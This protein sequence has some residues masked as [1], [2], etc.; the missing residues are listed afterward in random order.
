MPDGQKGVVSTRFYR[1]PGHVF[2]PLRR[3][4]DRAGAVLAVGAT[5]DEALARADA[6]AERIRFVTADAPALPDG[7]FPDGRAPDD[8][9]RQVVA[10][11]DVASTSAR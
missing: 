9:C 3:S 11:S 6:A 4:S 10:H 8:T 1:G 5:P 2:G 7:R